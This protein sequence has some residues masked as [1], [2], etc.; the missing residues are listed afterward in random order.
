[1]NRKESGGVS[2]VLWTTLERRKKMNVVRTMV[3]RSE[4][5][6]ATVVGSVFF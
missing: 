6:V 2:G 5:M 1:M 3:A 4:M